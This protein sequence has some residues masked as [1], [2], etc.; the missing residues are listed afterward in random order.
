MD[1]ATSV[2]RADNESCVRTSGDNVPINTGTLAGDALFLGG[3]TFVCADDVVV[4]GEADLNQIAVAS[5]LAAALEGPLFFPEP[6]LSAE[7]GRLKAIRV[8]VVGGAQV[9]VPGGAETINHDILSAVDAAKEALGVATEIAL[10]ATPDSATI[11]E[12]V[13]AISAGDRVVRP[14]ITTPGSSAPAPNIDATQVVVGLALNEISGSAWLVD[15]GSPETVLL[16][17]ATAGPAGASVIAVDGSD[18]L[19]Y[20]EV[21]TALEGQSSSS[22]RSIGPQGEAS[23]WE[24]AVLING[25]Q[26]PGGGFY[27]LPRESMRRYVA[28]YG[29]PGTDDLG[30]LGEQGP[31][32]TRALMQDFVDAYAGDGAQVIPTFEII[33]AVASAGAGDDGNYSF[34]WPPDTFTEWIDYAGANDMYVILDI[35]PGRTDFLTQV[36]V[37]E[38][39]LKLPYVGVALDPEWRLEPD[40]VHLEQV[41]SVEAAEVNEAVNWVADLVRDN[42][43][44][45]KMVIVHQF[46][47]SMIQNRAD[48]IER[49]E[50]QL[51]IQMDGDGTEPQKDNT[52]RVLMEGAD[53]AHWAWGWKN[54]FD[55]DEP[56]PPTPESTMSKE[57]SPVFVSYQ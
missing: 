40:Q 12:T 53:A 6:R 2:T 20:P 47:T 55:E 51:V 54:F 27:V 4:V 19:G 30:I 45:Q 37:Y 41:G 5:Q 36:K 50:I 8:H 16:G 31:A 44:P 42:G 32:E 15:V 3:E 21:A 25:V 34:E 1:G 18:L 10:S 29:F 33:V 14:A 39:L 24:R 13:N 43:L 17:S 52:W 57:P 38:E 28:F 35:Q 56:G 7:I 46:R 49:P 48:L 26:V 11:V 23:D 9:S 22:I